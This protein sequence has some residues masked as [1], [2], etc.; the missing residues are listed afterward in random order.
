MGKKATFTKATKQEKSQKNL[1]NVNKMNHK[2]KP[3]AI[4][5]NLK[6]VLLFESNL[7]LIIS[8]T[9]KNREE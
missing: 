3:K 2:K 8:M 6:K 5:T 4:K 9:K 1:F 7:Y